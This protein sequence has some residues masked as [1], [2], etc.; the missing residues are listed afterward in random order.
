[1]NTSLVQNMDIKK[2]KIYQIEKPTQKKYRKV[3]EKDRILLEFLGI[4][5]I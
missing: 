1:M 2:I 5:V 4:N 3:D